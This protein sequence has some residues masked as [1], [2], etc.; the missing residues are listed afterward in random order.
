M[1]IKNAAYTLKVVDK[2]GRSN[3]THSQRMVQLRTLM[4]TSRSRQ[5][6][7]RHWLFSTSVTAQKRLLLPIIPPSVFPSKRVNL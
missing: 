7:E 4:A 3:F 1:C 2:I 6:R 5:L